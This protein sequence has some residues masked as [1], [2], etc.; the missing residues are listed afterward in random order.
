MPTF[1]YWMLLTWAY[2]HHMSHC[3]LQIIPRKI[4]TNRSTGYL[5]NRSDPQTR[6]RVKRIVTYLMDSWQDT[7]RSIITSTIRQRKYVK[8]STQLVDVLSSRKT[9]HKQALLTE[10]GVRIKIIIS[11][12][13]FRGRRFGIRSGR[14]RLLQTWFLALIHMIWRCWID[15]HTVSGFLKQQQASHILHL[16]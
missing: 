15:F 3:K 14:G 5:L 1:N 8:N 13:H 12:R 16:G 4:A 9:R 2:L 11:T 7:N 10:M 6:H